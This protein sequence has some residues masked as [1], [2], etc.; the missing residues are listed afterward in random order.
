MSD[1]DERTVDNRLQERVKVG[2]IGFGKS[3]TFQAFTV[4]TD[5]S[6]N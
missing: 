5:Y 6:I 3:L 1:R 4:V 2:K